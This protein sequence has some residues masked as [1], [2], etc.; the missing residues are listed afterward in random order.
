[1]WI[2][3]GCCLPLT[4]SF[5]LQGQ[6]AEWGLRLWVEDVNAAG[7]LRVR[8]RR[9]V[10]PLALVVRDDAS[11]SS[12]AARLA[13]ELIVADQVDL[14][15]GPYSSAATLAV[16][17]VA[18]THRKVLWN[19]GGSSDALVHRGFRYIVNLPSPASQY[20]VGILDLA[21]ARS[22]ALC[23]LVLLFDPSGTFAPSVIGGAEVHAR[24]HG[25][26]VVGTAP[27]PTGASFAPLV[28]EVVA[29]RPDVLLGAGRLEADVA[30]ARALRA[31]PF[32]APIVGLVAAGI[33]HFGAKLGPTAEGFFGPSQWEPGVP[34]RPDVG[35]GAAEFAT[36]FRARFGVEPEYPAAQAYAAGLISQRCVELAGTLRDEAL[37]EAANALRLRTFYGEFRLDPVS[38]EQ[39]GH[40]M[41]IVQWQNG[42]RR[43]VWPAPDAE[44]EPHYS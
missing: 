20:F 28:T 8:D 37:R 44:A 14:L 24:R 33:A 27:Y 29:H 22:S 10:W 19:H 36:R 15:V 6:Q 42:A 2:K 9:G 3:V 17:Q 41:V 34:S 1:M 16:A 13:E 38:G 21:R 25:F 23:R 18:E 4:G 39:V 11:R 7:G 31:H 43:I 5:S 12:R 40:T 30:L 35:P 26:E 32:T